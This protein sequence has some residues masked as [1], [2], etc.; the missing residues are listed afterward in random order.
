MFLIQIQLQ[1]CGGKCFDL[2]TL[3]STLKQYQ[4]VNEE[5]GV[6]VEIVLLLF[7]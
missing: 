6:G 7:S 1:N 5:V 4:N 3:L 2:F